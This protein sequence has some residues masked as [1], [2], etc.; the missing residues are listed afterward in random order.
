M[1]RLQQL[2]RGMPGAGGAGV[3]GDSPTPDCA[4]KVHV[5]SLALLKMLKHGRAGVPMEVM[6]L[7]LGQ[8]VDDYTINCVDVFAMPQSGTSVSVEAVD[9]VFQTQMLDMLKQTGRPEMVVGWYHSHPGFGCWLSSTDINTQS[10]FEALNSRAV[11]LVVDPIQSVKGKVVID[12]FRLINPQ[13]MMLGQEP[14]QTTSNIGHLQKPSI[15]ALIHGLN[16]HYYSIV[17]DYRKNELEE[18][19]LMNLH[20]RNWTTGLT[21][22]KYEDH[23]ASTE[24]IVDKMLRLTK[25]YNERVKQEEGKTAEQVLVENVGKVDPKRHLE[26]HV[27]DLMS[28][29]IIQCLGTMLDTV[30]F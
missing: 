19:M 7:M 21:V 17:I 13:L 29:N 30:V 20:K 5:S 26:Q 9:P 16:R 10:S 28:S 23:Q 6:G 12:C 2:M 22:S 11:A 18:Q 27:S 25:D 1:E 3:A 8:F 4:E 14:R 15:Q 24:A